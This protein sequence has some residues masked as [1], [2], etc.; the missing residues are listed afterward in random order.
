[1]SDLLS[2]KCGQ[3]SVLRA[4]DW[5]EMAER[6]CAWPLPDDLCADAIACKPGA[7]HRTGT[8]LITITQAL[9][10][11]D[12]ACK[13]IIDAALTAERERAD[14]AEAVLECGHPASLMLHSAETGE[15]LYC[16]LCDMRS[17]RNDAVQM[18]EHYKAERDALR[19]R[20]GLKNKPIPTVH[21]ARGKE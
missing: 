16:E 7:P 21:G 5:S 12:Y 1:M 13:P 3:P 2:E 11:L 10:M 17:Q 8:N 18:E 19:D 14:R 4:E 6:I 9:A 15:P 20:L